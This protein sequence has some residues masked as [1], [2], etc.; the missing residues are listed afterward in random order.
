MAKHELSLCENWWSKAN[1]AYEGGSPI[2]TLWL[3]LSAKYLE[4]WAR[5]FQGADETERLA[6]RMTWES[7]WADGLS[8]AAVTGRQAKMALYACNR[9]AAPPTLPEFLALAMPIPDA[10]VAL[11]EAKRNLRAMQAGSEFAWSHPAVYWAA[12]AVGADEVRTATWAS[13]RSRWVK[14]LSDQLKRTDWPEAPV[15]VARGMSRAERDRSVGRQK[16]SD[17]LDLLN[18]K[19]A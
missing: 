19:A 5:Q 6:K 18:S 1:P 8:K 11:L 7:E 9:L 3:R 10:E 2:A 17:L 4:R 12:M 13:H 14:A 15:Y 16:L